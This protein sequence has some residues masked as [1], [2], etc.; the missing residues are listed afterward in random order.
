[1]HIKYVA[2]Y[3]PYHA[4]VIICAS[5]TVYTRVTSIEIDEPAS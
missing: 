5:C 1:M 2:L 4:M 3:M